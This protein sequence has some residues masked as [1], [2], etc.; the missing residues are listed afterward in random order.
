MNPVACHCASGDELPSDQAPPEKNAVAQGASSIGQ[1]DLNQARHE[2]RTVA[3][4]KVFRTSMVAKFGCWG[5]SFTSF[6]PCVSS[7]KSRSF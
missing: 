7:R 4:E 1:R 3:N 5:F 6:S 2:G